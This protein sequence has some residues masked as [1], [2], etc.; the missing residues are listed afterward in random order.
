MYIKKVSTNKKEQTKS[1]QN[2]V[3]CIWSDKEKEY[4]RL[5]ILLEKEQM[6]SS[7]FHSIYLMSILRLKRSTLPLKRDGVKIYRMFLYVVLKISLSN[8]G[9]TR[10]PRERAKWSID[11]NTAV[12]ALFVGYKNSA[13][14]YWVLHTFILDFST[15]ISIE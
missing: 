12:I 14:T 10:L 11:K 3:F 4:S 8:L 13:V 5:H 9:S 1:P 15:N 2:L 7:S 6:C